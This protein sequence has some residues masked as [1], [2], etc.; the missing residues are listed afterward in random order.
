[1]E[2]TLLLLLFL[3]GNTPLLFPPLL[4]Q[5]EQQQGTWLW[6]LLR[7]A[8]G[9]YRIKQ[10][11]YPAVPAA[12]C[13]KYP[14]ALSAANKPAGAAAGYLSSRTAASFLTLPPFVPFLLSNLSNIAG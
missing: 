3:P 7:F 9:F 4:N 12:R 14:A 6:L 8:F 5:P 11:K 2:S 10:N 1:L 13:V